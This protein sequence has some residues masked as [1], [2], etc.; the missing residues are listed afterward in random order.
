M[1]R[2]CW[3][4]SCREEELVEYLYIALKNKDAMR[5]AGNLPKLVSKFAKSGVV[6]SS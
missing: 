6:P 1:G 3:Y 4:G 5:H 2:L